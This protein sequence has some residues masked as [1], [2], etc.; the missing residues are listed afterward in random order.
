MSL[1]LISGAV[2]VVAATLV[3]MLPMRLQWVPGLALLV[4]APALLAW[5]AVDQGW[6]VFALG[7]FAFVSMFRRPLGYLVRRALGHIEEDAA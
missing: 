7:A 2:W 4:A 5:I 3:A 1:S 6:W